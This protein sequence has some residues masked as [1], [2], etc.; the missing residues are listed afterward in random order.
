MQ[1]LK[2]FIYLPIKVE[3]HY[4]ILVNRNAYNNTVQIITVKS[5]IVQALKVFISLAKKVEDH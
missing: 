4:K 2:L 1:A 3:D 5:F